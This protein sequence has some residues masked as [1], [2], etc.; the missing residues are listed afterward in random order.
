[1]ESEKQMEKIKELIKDKK[2]QAAILIVFVCMLFIIVFAASRLGKSR[3]SGHG[4]AEAS[5]TDSVKTVSTEDSKSAEKGTE[6]KT[7][8]ELETDVQGNVSSVVTEN[9]E[10]IDLASNEVET[11]IKPDGSVSYKL[12]DGSEIVVNQ[13]GTA[14]VNR[15]EEV[16]Q[17]PQSVTNVKETTVAA[18]GSGQAGENTSSDKGEETTIKPESP[19][20][21]NTQPPSNTVNPPTQPL[22]AE[23][24][25]QL[26]T[27]CQHV[28][29]TRKVTTAATS[30]SHG[31]WAVVCDSCGSTL[32]TGT[33]HSYGAYS[34]DLGGGQ[35]ATVYGYFDDEIADE[36]FKQLNTYRQEN[37]LPVLEN[38]FNEES[39]IRAMECAYL[40]SHDRPNGGEFWI[41][42]LIGGEN[43]GMLGSGIIVSTETPKSLIAAELM[44]NWKNSYGHNANMLTEDEL[45]GVGVFVSMVIDSD[46]IANREA[47]YAV[48]NFGTEY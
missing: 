40:F 41:N 47:I 38:R 34:V 45:G 12:A 22:T 15:K 5:N 23:P 21:Q 46:G 28:N 32:E 31:A 20:V 37:G 14:K 48:Q 19:T 9:G 6:K 27:A 42:D 13:N 43:L 16:S 33:I 8:I 29:T 17:P 2:I 11:E 3:Q 39:K 25:V 10:T 26:S 4:V 1:M 30:S 18:N 36:I 35:T 24:P 44:K 7:G